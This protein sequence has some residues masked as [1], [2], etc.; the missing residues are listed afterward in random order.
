MRKNG[1]KLISINQY[2]WGDLCIFTIIAAIAELVCY[3]AQFWFSSAAFYTLNLMLPLITLV[4][5]RWGWWG[6]VLASLEGIMYCAI[7]GAIW[8]GYIVIILSNAAI[9][10]ELL[11]IW[12]IKKDRLKK[13][14][15]WAFLLVLIGWVSVNFVRTCLYAAFGMSD[16]LSALGTNFGFS[17]CGLLALVIG[18]LVILVCRKLDGLFEDQKSYLLRLKKEREEQA[19]RDEFGDEPVVIDEESLSILNRRD[20]L[21]K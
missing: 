2:R 3:F 10:V 4:I 6:V 17:D 21:Y 15:Y 18:E 11:F 1:S 14:W 5:V 20:D 7:R 12:L 16:F 9:A 13:N 8:Q 19:R